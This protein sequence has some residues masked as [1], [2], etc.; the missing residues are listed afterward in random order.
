ERLYVIVT[1][2][3]LSGVPIE[4]ELVAYCR[5]STNP[6]LWRPKESGWKQLIAGVDSATSVR[7]VIENIS[8]EFGQALT[9]AE[10]DAVERGLGLGLDAPA[11]SVIR[12]NKSPQAKQIVT[13]IALIHK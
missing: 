1:K 6:C 3:A 12:M 9:T 2:R 13:M 7:P 11:P 10:R 5:T 4:N 8:K